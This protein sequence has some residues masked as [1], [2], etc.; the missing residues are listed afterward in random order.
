MRCIWLFQE[1]GYNRLFIYNWCSRWMRIRYRKT[2]ARIIVK[3]W[4]PKVFKVSRALEEWQ[5]MTTIELVHTVNNSVVLDLRN[6]LTIAFLE[7]FH[8]VNP[9]L[10]M[11]WPLGMANMD[12]V[13]ATVE[14][15]TDSVW[16]KLTEDIIQKLEHGIRKLILNKAWIKRTHL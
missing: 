5:K 11:L 14:L 16:C 13:T 15:A 9:V 6:Q 3:W 12:G 2:D 1:D 4:I 7:L 10:E 8:H